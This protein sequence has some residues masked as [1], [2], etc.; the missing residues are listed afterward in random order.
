MK[1]SISNVVAGGLITSATVMGLDAIHNPASADII[2]SK[3]T[4]DFNF[5]FGANALTCCLN[6]DTGSKDFVFDGFDPRLGVL[7]TISLGISLSD[8]TLDPANVSDFGGVIAGQ[9]LNTINLDATQFVESLN[10]ISLE[11]SQF[12]Q[13]LN[14]ISLDFNILFADS[15]VFTSGET[16]GNVTLSYFYEPSAVPIPGSVALMAPALAAL[17]ASGACRRRRREEDD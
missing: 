8:L 15:P 1:K 2:E 6:I 13:D 11:A 3:Q 14:T 7:N 10:T 4:Q 12:G 16:K 5:D 17:L 9:N